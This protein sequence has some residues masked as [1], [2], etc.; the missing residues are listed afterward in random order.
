MMR[1]ASYVQI[2]PSTQRESTS[3]VMDLKNTYQ[4]Q[5][6]APQFS[7]Y[8]ARA[9]LKVDNEE[10]LLQPF[11]D[12]CG[13]LEGPVELLGSCAKQFSVKRVVLTS[14]MVS[15]HTFSVTIGME[16]AG[17]KVYTSEDWATDVKPPYSTTFAAYVQS[18]IAALR[19]A[20]HWMAKNKPS[21]DIITIHP[22][23][24]DAF[25]DTATRAADLLEGT[26]PYFLAPALGK[27]ASQKTGANIAKAHIKSLNES[28]QGHQAFLLTNKG[29][30]IAMN[31]AK[32]IVE[33][34]FP[35]AVGT[36][37]PNDG[38]I[39]P[40]LF[41][42]LNIEKTEKAFGKLKSFDETISSLVGQYP[43]LLAKEES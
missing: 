21:F 25:N 27:E 35:N 11:Y 40:H 5:G 28:V 37:L 17:D 10:A 30:D 20:E 23:F 36:K 22:S 19:A 2:G 26:N 43:S 34:H 4:P 38:N 33:K 18:K 15:I 39:E 29:G 24:V 8:Q 31:D 16:S 7:S 3:R 6:V 32:A 42:S 41:V 14:S 9:Q 1:T 13:Q 12:C